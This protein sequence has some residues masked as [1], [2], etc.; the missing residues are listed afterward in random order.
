MWRLP[1][2]HSSNEACWLHHLHILISFFF[3]PTKSWEAIPDTENTFCVEWYL[4]TA[5]RLVKHDQA[6]SSMVKLSKL[7]AQGI[8]C[9]SSRSR[10]WQPSAAAYLT[11]IS[12]RWS[13]SHDELLTVQ[14]WN[15][16]NEKK[17]DKSLNFWSTILMLVKDL[18]GLGLTFGEL[19]VA[20]PEGQHGSESSPWIASVYAMKCIEHRLNKLIC[21]LKLDATGSVVT[22]VPTAKCGDFNW[23][24]RQRRKHSEKV[25]QFDGTHRHSCTVLRQL[26]TQIN[27][28]YS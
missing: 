2:K 26:A 10:G 13:W 4:V 28:T 11:G 21:A 3:C 20:V 25:A 23:T 15:S 27:T 14:S 1:I 7:V 6:W 12:R 17:N 22:T 5:S 16:K 24:A 18:R 9:H 19:L 8:F